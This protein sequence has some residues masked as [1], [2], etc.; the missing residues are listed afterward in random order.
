MTDLHCIPN[1]VIKI[2]SLDSSLT[3]SL[4]LLWIPTICLCLLCIL[5]ILF[6]S[7]KQFIVL[8]SSV[9]V[10]SRSLW[11]G[12]AFWQCP[13]PPARTASS[14]PPPHPH[15][16]APR[17]GH[18]HRRDP[19]PPTT[20]AISTLKQMNPATCSADVPHPVIANT[21]IHSHT[22][23]KMLS[24]V[25]SWEAESQIFQRSGQLQ[26]ASGA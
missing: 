20:D 17:T 16:R 23:S 2:I 3:A 6:L 12:R 4:P 1:I 18:H 22:T 14:S 15:R 19:S 25:D 26:W 13:W 10:H 9:H 7:E 11:H 8:Y 24:S 5:S 21:V